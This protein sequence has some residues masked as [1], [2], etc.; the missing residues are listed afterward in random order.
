MLG[1]VVLGVFGSM[2]SQCEHDSRQ[3]AGAKAEAARLSAMTPEQRAAE[4]AAKDKRA[5]AEAKLEHLNQARFA[6]EEFVKRSLHDPD[7]A[8]FEDSDTFFAE[9]T[10][11]DSYRVQARL[12]AK[13]GFGA[14]RKIV[15]ECRLLSTKDKWV[16]TSVRP[17]EN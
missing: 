5:Q 2:V 11:P 4:Q 3:E 15:V 13:N 7:S 8:Q 10:K 16:A 14:L 9:E 12:R 6:C 17:L 1:L